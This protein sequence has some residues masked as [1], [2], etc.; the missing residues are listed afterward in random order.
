MSNLV[1]ISVKLRFK[2]MMFED[3][4]IALEIVW[5]R[6]STSNI[7]KNAQKPAMSTH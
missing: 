6:K 7:L 3:T 2:R 4:L 1:L 5:A